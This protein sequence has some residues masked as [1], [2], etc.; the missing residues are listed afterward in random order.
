[1]STA[2]TKAEDFALDSMLLKP[3]A[4]AYQLQIAR[5]RVFA[6]IKSGELESVRVGTSRRVPREALERYLEKLR[7][8]S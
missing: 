7:A 6:L 3:E 4:V 5:T 8:A 2:S 1:M